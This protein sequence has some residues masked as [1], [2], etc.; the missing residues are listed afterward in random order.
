MN[1]TRPQ[2]TPE[3]L[4]GKV[5]GV[6]KE[7]SSDKQ[8]HYGISTADCL[9]SAFAM[10][11][12]KY[13]SLLQFDQARKHKVLSH[14]LKML[15]GVKEIPCDTYMRERLDGQPVEIVRKAIKPLIGELQRA[16]ALEQWKFLGKY[17][18]ISLDATGFFSSEQVH[19]E[20]CCEKKYK[21]GTDEEYTIYNHQMLVGVI[22]HPD[23]RQVL[24]I[25]FEPIIKADGDTK[26]D[27]ERN[28]AKRWLKNF[29]RDYPQLPVVFLGD[30]LFSNAP[31]IQEVEAHRGKYIII[32]KEKDHKH[33]YDYFWKAE[34]LD[35]V[36][37]KET[38]KGVQKRYRYMSNV[39]LNDSHPDLLVNVVFYEEI[40]K[41]NVKHQWLWVTNL[42]LTDHKIV[43]EIARGGRCRWKIENETFN[44][45]KNQGYHYEHNFGHGYKTLSNLLAGLM[46]LAFLVDQCLEALTVEFKGALAKCG[47]RINLWETI[48][49]LFGWV[50]IGNWDKLYRSILDPPAFAF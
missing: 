18:P 3:A 22:V 16:K 39:P 14:N 41:K 8:G 27:C 28:A 29:R 20:Y 34:E 47:S 44:T 11:S 46:L 49:F 50:L 32:A 9:M 21:K 23:M 7:H 26:N 1:R 5:R 2:F 31:F 6:F 43:K 35:M 40:D 15:Y 13:P 19:C 12:L 42:E 25:G 38:I 37:F 4:F 24:P 33:L 36:E 17:Y 30:G 45:L 48:R 10:F